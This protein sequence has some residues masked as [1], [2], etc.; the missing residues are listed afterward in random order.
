MVKTG[1]LIGILVFAFTC[2]A[3]SKTSRVSTIIG[4][5]TPGFS[6]RQINNPY[7]VVIGPDGALYFCDLDNQRI[8]RLDL[9]TP[10]LPTI[11]GKGTRGYAG[12]GESRSLVSYHSTGI[13]CHL[14]DCARCRLPNDN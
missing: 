12:D 14:N 11:A 3:Q 4:D 8:R 6:D 1:Y 5:G 9:K 13:S 7:G 10:A 2:L